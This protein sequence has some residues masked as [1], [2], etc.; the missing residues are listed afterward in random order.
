MTPLASASS[1]ADSLA[2][3]PVYFD[4]NPLAEKHLTGIA[5]Y[6]A[7]LAMAMARRAQVR[8]FCGAWELELPADLSWS[9]DQ[10]LKT[11]ARRVSRS[12]RKPLAPPSNA[13]GVWCCLRPVERWFPFEAS[14]LYDFTPQIVPQT[15]TPRV[16]ALFQ[17]FC[18]LA[19]PNS[20]MA[21]AI[22]HSTKA[23]AGWLT[24]LSSE[25]I[26]VAYPG[27]S[28]CI[29]KHAH[30]GPVERLPHVGLVVSTLEP[31]KNAPFVLDWFLNTTTL[32][33]NAELWWVGPLGWLTSWRQLR[34]YRRTGGRRV[35]FL[36][37]VSDA[38]LCELQQQAG[39]SIYPSL[40]EG[41]GFP[42]LDALRH[43]AP[44]LTSCNS[45]LR[46]FRTPGVYFFDPCDAATLDRAWLNLAS[47]GPIDTQVE[48]LDRR[49]NW[50][51]AAETLLAG[52]RKHRLGQL[53]PSVRQFE[54]AAA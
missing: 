4:A 19:L 5:R 17:G 10:D 42:V 46:E 16:Q 41:F 3:L 18:A 25:R 29:E 44:V 22:S 12:P 30:V 43:G 23:D 27:P 15:H 47:A 21:L 26:E 49:Y 14:I 31:R 20:D 54:R 52:Y 2:S 33:A 34:K 28:L 11:W 53:V 37:V 7:R 50:D 48:Q 32:P 24:D 45:S 1:D 51:V 6:T 9:P 36:G 38:R 13:F 39:W 35:R 40:Y 8:F